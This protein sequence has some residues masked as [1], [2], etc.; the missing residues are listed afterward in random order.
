MAFLIVAITLCLALAAGW[1]ANRI[2]RYFKQSHGFKAPRKDHNSPAISSNQSHQ[3]GIRNTP[4]QPPQV[5]LKEKEARRSLHDSPHQQKQDQG[6]RSVLAFPLPE[7]N[8]CLPTSAVSRDEPPSPPLCLIDP[9][10]DDW[11]GGA[12]GKYPP[13]WE[14]RSLATRIRDEHH[15]QITGCPS[16]EQLHVHHLKA[17]K[18]GGSH[19][20]TNLIT[21]CEFH[22]ALMPDHLEAIGE[23]TRSSRYSVRSG[24]HR[25]NQV[26]VGTHYVTPHIMRRKLADADSIQALIV[27]QDLRCP[28]CGLASLEC[29]DT[30]D[31]G[32][33]KLNA[34]GAERQFK[35]RVVCGEHGDTWYFES[36]L[37]EESGLLLAH[38]CGRKSH[39]RLAEY[40]QVWLEDGH[41]LECPPCPRS[42]CTGHLVWRKNHQ[43][44][45]LFQGCSNYFATECSG[46]TTR[47]F[48]R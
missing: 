1:I 44:G 12:E 18:D 20:Q 6:P 30:W 4:V 43:D 48:T 3:S 19:A 36:A 26:R 27:E 39:P 45:S 29:E 37:L 21:L 11:K 10:F 35:S 16:L 5:E 38:L 42:D 9:N 14:I 46:R 22:H 24:F 15:C 28:K 34:E 47:R 25:Q 32:W 40:E 17:I 31:I 8:P 13:D 41:R 23:G 7:L 33:A 2:E